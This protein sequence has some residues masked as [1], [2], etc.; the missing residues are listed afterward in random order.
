MPPRNLDQEQWLVYDPG[1][2]DRSGAVFTSENDAYDYW[3]EDQDRE[4]VQFNVVE[5]YSR[6]V[7]DDF[8]ERFTAANRPAPSRQSAF[9]CPSAWQQASRADRDNDMRWGR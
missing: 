8:G 6:D 5:G 4:A 9:R 1:R 2:W 3:S 7:T